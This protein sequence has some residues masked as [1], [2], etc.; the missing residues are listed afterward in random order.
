MTPAVAGPA[1]TTR[2]APWHLASLYRVRYIGASEED[3]LLGWI[4]ETPSINGLLGLAWLEGRDP[5]ALASLF[6]AVM[7]RQAPT[8]VQLRSVLPASHPL[9][10]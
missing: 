10:P 7:Y 4:K 3:A 6:N 9:Q 8:P 2:L 5:V 1:T